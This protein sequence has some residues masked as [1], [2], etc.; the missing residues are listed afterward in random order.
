[1][2][3]HKEQYYKDELTKDFLEETVIKLL[4]FWPR[5]VQMDDDTYDKILD[6]F[7]ALLHEDNTLNLALFLRNVQI[8][9]QTEGVVMEVDGTNFQILIYPC[10]LTGKNKTSR[11]QVYYD[12]LRNFY[13]IWCPI[14]KS[15]NNGNNDNDSNSDTNDISNS[16]E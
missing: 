1:M 12:T 8:C 4:E 9:L 14:L 16:I 7:I 6:P 2:S 10:G 3:T 15:S 11:E 5:G 13:N